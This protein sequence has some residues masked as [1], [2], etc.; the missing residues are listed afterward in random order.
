ME[1]AVLRNILSRGPRE[2]KLTERK[3]LTSS[4]KI[5]PSHSSQ[6]I[7]QGPGQSR[8]VKEAWGIV[9][10]LPTRRVIY[11]NYLN[12]GASISYYTA[13]NFLEL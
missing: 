12:I 4:Q 6:F 10:L 7:L 5:P 9:G 8:L 13:W 11:A 3:K 2:G 1:R